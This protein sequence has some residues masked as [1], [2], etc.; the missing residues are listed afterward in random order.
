MPRDPSRR[1]RRPHTT[2]PVGE[3]PVV[4]LAGL[5]ALGLAGAAAAQPVAPPAEVPGLLEERRPGEERLPLPEFERPE[6]VLPPLRPLPPEERPGPAV[7][8]RV[9]VRDIELTG[10]TVF[11]DAELGEV[12]APYDNRLIGN[13]DL[14]ALRQALTLYY[15]ERGYINS[16][17]VIPDQKVEQGVVRIH[18]VEGELTSMEV[19]GN[20]RLRADYLTKR[21]ALAAGPPLN[22]NALQEQLQILLQDPVITRVNADLRPGDRPG[23]A[24]LLLNVEEPPLFGLGLVF[25]NHVSP[26]IGGFRGRILGTMRNPTGWGDLINAEAGFAEGLTEVS[27]SY[28]VPV[29]RWDTRLTLFGERIDSEV[30]DE[31]F[32]DLDIE[33]EFWSAGVQ[34]SQPLYRTPREEINLTLGFERRES[35]TSLLGVPFAFSPGVEPDGESKVS[36]VRFGQDWLRRTADR[37]FAARSQLSL[38]ID[39]FNPTINADAPDGRFVSWL[40]QFQWAE[41]IGRRGHQLLFRLDVQLASDGLLP[42]EQFAVGGAQSVRGYRENQL[43]RDYGFVTSLEYRI[44]VL[45]GLFRDSA[46]RPTLQLAPFV[47]G[48]GAWNVDRDT[49]DPRTISSAGVGLRW[50]PHRRVHAE[51]Y[52]AAPLREIDNPGHDLQDEGIHFLLRVTPF[53]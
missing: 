24:K 5:I 22:V 18:I 35:Q 9:F 29:T 39:A 37:V 34:L 45:R 17:A 36:V 20:Q 40:G 38:G 30:V 42:L 33:S 10:N 6:D 14:D 51:L 43:V 8:V 49:P 31:P 12:T 21:L 2:R 3:F 46:G 53:E 1:W 27:G 44:P 7:G 13:E 4:V 25:D 47:D 26:S 16:G 19:A 32:E 15:V 52:W 41:R 28:S 48:G 11:S 50:D 23:E